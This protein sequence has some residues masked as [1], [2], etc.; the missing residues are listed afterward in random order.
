MQT[1]LTLRGNPLAVNMAARMTVMVA[2]LFYAL[3]Q[4]ILI[5]S[6]DMFMN[7]MLSL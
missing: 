7:Q 3:L 5:L 6:N 1:Q 4:G 2:M